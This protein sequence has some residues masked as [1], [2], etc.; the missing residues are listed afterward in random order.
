M[1][2]NPRG[3]YAR[4]TPKG[5]I[6]LIPRL[7]IYQDKDSGAWCV[8]T[9]IGHIVVPTSAAAYERARGVHHART[10]V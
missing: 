3:Y 8:D 6:H 2:T 10:E 9:G 5:V 1:F 7:H 4:N